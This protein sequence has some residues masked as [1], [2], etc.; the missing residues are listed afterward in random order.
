MPCFFW[1]SVAAILCDAWHFHL[2]GRAE[3]GFQ[4]AMDDLE[5]ELEQ[6][7]DEEDEAALHAEAMQGL[8]KKKQDREAELEKVREEARLEERKRLQAELA[9]REAAEQAERAKLEEAR[10]REVQAREDLLRQEKLREQQ[11]VDKLRQ[12]KLRQEKLRQEKLRQEGEGRAGPLPE[13]KVAKASAPGSPT[14]AMSS[15]LD[16][17][18][19]SAELQKLRQEE[20]LLQQQIQQVESAQ[21]DEK[22]RKVLEQRAKNEQL[23]QKLAKLAPS[24][25]PASASASSGG[26]SAKAPPT[27]LL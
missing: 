15:Q 11:E 10:K 12:E 13:A 24:L 20:S 18:P 4:R 16:M 7:M 1:T 25:T 17:S 9:A 14:R 22:K 8:E 3:G 23:R 26:E 6:A 27:R 21:V 2:L 5:S 19:C